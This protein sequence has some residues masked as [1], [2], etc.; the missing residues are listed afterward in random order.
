MN[1]NQRRTNAMFA[2]A[3]GVACLLMAL[4]LSAQV[5]SSTSTTSQTPTVTSTTQS[6]TVVY[7]SGNDLIVKAD[8][9]TLHHFSNVPDNKTVTVDGKQLTIHDLKP[10][11][12][13]TR[14]I[15]T[16]TTPK[17]ITTT[18]S[19]TGKVWQVNPPASVILTMDNGQNQMFKIPKGQM[20]NVNGQMVDAMHLQKGMIVNA[21]RITESPE[22]VT[23]QSTSVT[24][25]MPQQAAA[26][27]PPPPA[28]DVP[29]LIAVVTPIPAAA[30][31]ALPKTG[32]SLPLVGFLGQLLIAT[33]LGMKAIR[34]LS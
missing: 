10:G 29:I 1:S 7:V 33:S 30:P 31:A 12:R 14:T 27:P 5:Q 16:T 26:P 19:V 8:D 11:M 13:L 21:T 24:G 3:V 25:S 32:S 18:Q 34:R 23:T 15:T 22:T 6:G 9:G 4:N 20:F 2:L 28:P 17:T